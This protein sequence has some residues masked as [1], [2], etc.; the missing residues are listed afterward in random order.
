MIDAR[1]I[2]VSKVISGPKERKELAERINAVDRY[3]VSEDPQVRLDE[4]EVDAV[5]AAGCLIEHRVDQGDYYSV[6][7]YI[8]DAE[9]AADIVHR[10]VERIEKQARK[11]EEEEAAWRSRS[12]ELTGTPE[13]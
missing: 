5:R 6:A 2:T 12:G 4:S 9:L 10:A 1:R 8:T 11:R 7:A 13:E 3:L